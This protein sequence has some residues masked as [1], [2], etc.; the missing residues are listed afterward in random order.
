MS[1]QQYTTIQQQYTQQ[2]QSRSCT[3][4]CEIESITSASTNFRGREG[5]RERVGADPRSAY[6]LLCESNMEWPHS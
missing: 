6:V 3:I 2:Q 1:T 4:D 5:S